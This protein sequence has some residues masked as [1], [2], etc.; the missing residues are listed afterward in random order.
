MVKCF[1]VIE[2]LSQFGRINLP[3]RSCP[4]LDVA[5]FGTS[6]KARLFPTNSVV[7]GRMTA[8][9]HVVDPRVSHEIVS[10]VNLWRKK[11]LPQAL[12]RQLTVR[13]LGSRAVFMPPTVKVR[14]VPVDFCCCNRIGYLETAAQA[15]VNCHKFFDTRKIYSQDFFALGIS[16]NFHFHRRFNCLR[17]HI[18]R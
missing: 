8:P 13:L 16:K 10:R 14:E 9:R 18:L 11:G 4:D 2:F 1:S 3:N 15:S 12:T 17:A 5:R 7:N 6:G